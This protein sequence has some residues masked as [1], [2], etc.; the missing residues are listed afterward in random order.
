MK[1]NSALATTLVLAGL[2]LAALSALAGFLKKSIAAGILSIVV[3]TVVGIPKVFPITQRAEYRAL[4]GQSSSLLLQA[5]LR[6]NPTL[7]D[8]NEFAHDIQL[9]AE[10]EMN[11]F[12]A[13]GDVAQNTQDLIKD[14]AASSGTVH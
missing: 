7:A 1:S 12:P 13:G 2:I 3:T 4:F 5:Q 9:L 8:Y 10:Y 6:L 14:I 11:K